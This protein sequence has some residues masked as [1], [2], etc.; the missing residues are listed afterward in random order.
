[1]R[2]LLVG[3]WITPGLPRLRDSFV[4]I[5]TKSESVTKGPSDGSR[6]ID[7]IGDWFALSVR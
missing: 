2:L 3:D 4:C 1:M 6:P 7:G 5:K